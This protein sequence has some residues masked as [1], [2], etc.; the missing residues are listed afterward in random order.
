MNL[1]GKRVDIPLDIAVDYPIEWGFRIVLRDL[2][3]NFYDA[4]G[5]ER[6][7]KDF[8]YTWDKSDTGDFYD[9]EM[10]TENHPF[11]YEWLTYVGGSTKTE[12]NTD[13]VGKYGEGF[14]MSVLRLVQMGDMRLTMHSQGWLISPITYDEEIDG[15]NVTMLGYEY[16]E[17]DDDGI[18]RLT[19]SGI[20][21]DEK[22]T[23][24]NALLDYFYEGND[25]I[26]EKIG[27]GD[28]YT[29]YYR[30]KVSI[31]CAQKDESLKGILFV[32]HLAR[33]RL[34][35][36]LVINVQSEIYWDKRSRPTFTQVETI[37]YLY[38]SIVKW[39]PSDSAEVL[40]VLNPYWSD[41]ISSRYDVNSKYYIVCQL[42]RNIAKDR[43]VSE[44]FSEEMKGMAFIEK[45]GSDKKRNRTIEETKR[46]WMANKSKRLVNPIFRL[47]GAENLVETYMSIKSDAYRNPNELEKLRYIVL[48]KAVMSVVPMLK[49]EDI[50]GFVI[51]ENDNERFDPLQFS[52]RVYGSRKERLGR[53]YHITKLVMKAEDFFDDNFIGSFIKV[54][55]AFL[56]SFGTSKSAKVN[57]LLTY[58]G[59]WILENDELLTLYEQ[60]WMK[61]SM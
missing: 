44:S 18:T 21:L 43:A 17:V 50:S 1:N 6:F 7:E 9:L 35:F 23:I 37:K 5:S 38:Q 13:N 57:G 4:I 51:A 49:T 34:D 53:K 26:A 12:N 42:V 29:I 41:S 39:R 25:L 10:S 8:Y 15:R 56:Q 32:N 48:I 59:E 24:Q 30:S 27:E 54:A 31:P 40:R 28:C 3:Q 20:P 58:L 19:L 16:Q 22:E 55:D 33:G 36:P 46:W 11:S 60:E 52:E 2:V 14:K 45:K 61:Q 47:L